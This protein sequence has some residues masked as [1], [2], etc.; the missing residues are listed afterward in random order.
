MNLLKNGI[1]YLKIKGGKI[2]FKKFFEWAEIENNASINDVDSFLKEMSGKSFKSG[3]YRIHNYDEIKKW[4]KIVEDA[5]QKYTG[6]IR[7]FGYDWLGRQF[8]INKDTNTILL[9]E[10]GTGEVLDIP[11]DFYNFHNVEIAEYHEDSLASQFF[12]EW[13]KSSKEY[14]LLH[15]ECVG[16]K[17]PLFLNGNDDINNLE[18]S[19]MEVYWGLMGQLL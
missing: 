18:V 4:I 9:F 11:V 10:S 2:V 13:Y 14:T 16:Y 15:N 3:M 1:N 5:F 6:R 7:I 19:D 17:V 12:A 8:A